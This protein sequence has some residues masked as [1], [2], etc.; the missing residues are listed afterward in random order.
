ML[1]ST[2]TETPAPPTPTTPTTAAALVDIGIIAIELY[3][4]PLYVEQS[5]LEKHDGVLANKYTIGLGQ[6]RLATM[7][8]RME[9][10]VSMALTVCKNML[11]RYPSSSIG[12]LECGTESNPDHAKSIKSSLMSLFGDNDSL[13][14]VDNVN[15]CYGGTAALLNSVCWIESRDWDGRMAM[16]VMSDQSSYSLR[17]GAR[18]TGG[19]AAVALLIGPDSSVSLERGTCSNY[20]TSNWDFWRPFGQP[21][22]FFDG[23][24]SQDLYLQSFK[25]TFEGHKKKIGTAADAAGFLTVLSHAPFYKMVQ[26]TTRISGIP[27][28]DELRWTRDIGNSYCCSLYIS[29]ANLLYVLDDVGADDGVGVGVAIE[30]QKDQTPPSKTRVG[31]FSYGSGSCSS[32]FSF[33]LKGPTKGIID[34][35]KVESMFG[36]RRKISPMQYYSFL[37][38]VYDNDT[39]DDN[40]VVGDASCNPKEKGVYY[41]RNGEDGRRFYDCI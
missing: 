39:A 33:I 41:L 8:P 12:R 38:D 32:F 23:P 31:M 13:W 34:K 25:K 36:R 5:E 6:N 1:V 20:M 30:G 16:V 18:A 7:N 28:L 10:P 21:F 11:L 14:G 26:K 9:D 27:L 15:A 17:G 19:A 35:T 3:V 22:P 29:L 4:P 40:V 2:A 24:K 37:D